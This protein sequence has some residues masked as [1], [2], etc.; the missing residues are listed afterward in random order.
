MSYSNDL[1]VAS[2]LPGT[3][4]NDFPVHTSGGFAAV[5]RKVVRVAGVTVGAIP[6]GSTD[7]LSSSRN[8]GRAVPVRT[9]P[10]WAH[11]SAGRPEMSGVAFITIRSVPVGIT[12]ASTSSCSIDAIANMAVHTRS[13]LAT[14]AAKVDGQIGWVELWIKCKQS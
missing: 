13:G 1:R 12:G 10:L 4:H 8:A 3:A 14:I 5:R 11:A 9:Q 6:F 7:A 2:T